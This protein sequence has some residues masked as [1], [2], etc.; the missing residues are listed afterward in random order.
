MTTRT[1]DVSRFLKES[2]PGDTLTYHTGF[3]AQDRLNVYSFGG[4]VFTT[5][6][7]TVDWVGN[8]MWKAYQRGIVSLFQKKL[9]DNR[10]SYIAKRR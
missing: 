10:Y 3:L 2:K 5:I 1:E 8:A 9:G 6:N 7:T 4:D